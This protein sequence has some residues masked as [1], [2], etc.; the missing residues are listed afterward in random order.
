[1]T[2]QF[3]DPILKRKYD[4]LRRAYRTASKTL[5][6]ADGTQFAGTPSADYFWQGFHNLAPN[7]GWDDTSRRTSG[8]AAW[9]A[10]RDSAPKDGTVSAEFNN[11]PPSSTAAPRSVSTPSNVGFYKA[12]VRLDPTLMQVLV[13]PFT[14]RIYRRRDYT[15]FTCDVLGVQI[16]RQISYPSLQQ[17]AYDL[18][19]KVGTGE[20]DNAEVEKLWEQVIA[21]PA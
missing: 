9:R 11:Y 1:M 16:T 6:N 15:L 10:G 14:V 4:T 18:S 12:T 21:N 7:G 13:G 17:L 3:K 2:A 5:L 19:L 20:L 8:Y